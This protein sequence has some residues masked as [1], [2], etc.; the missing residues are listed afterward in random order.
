MVVMLEA[1][2]AKNVREAER[3]VPVRCRELKI[4]K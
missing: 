4:E 2:L 3:F 1:E